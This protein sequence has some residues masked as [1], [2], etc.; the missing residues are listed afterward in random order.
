MG[1]RGSNA[2]AARWYVMKSI[3]EIEIDVPRDQ[4][5]ALFADPVNLTKWMNDLD[6]I[7]P[8]GGERGMPGSQYRMVGKAD[9]HM[10]FVATV[11]ARDLPERVALKLESASV[12]IAITDTFMALSAHRTKLTSEEVFTFRGLAN[13]LFGFLARRTIHENHRRH[14]ESFRRFAEAQTS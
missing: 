5:T 3:V 2:R 11:V 9:T 10:D 14:M 7:E 1:L 4:T 13:I 8:I 6:R 12:D